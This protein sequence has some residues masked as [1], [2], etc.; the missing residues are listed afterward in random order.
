LQSS[1]GPDEAGDLEVRKAGSISY[2]KGRSDRIDRSTIDDCQGEVWACT[3]VDPDVSFRVYDHSK[4]R[5]VPKLCNVIKM[6]RSTPLRLDHL[7]SSRGSR[8]VDSQSVRG[9][10][11]GG[12]DDEVSRDP[13]VIGDY[14][15]HRNIRYGQGVE[16]RPISHC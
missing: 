3:G 15:A 8:V 6:S 1:E 7:Q 10:D 13:Q 11:V 4:C 9:L 2:K 14:V 16:G 12:R 5:I